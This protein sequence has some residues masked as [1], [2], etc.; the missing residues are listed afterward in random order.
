[1]KLAI[2]NGQ[3]HLPSVLWLPGISLEH[4]QVGHQLEIHGACMDPACMLHRLDSIKHLVSYKVGIILFT[5][6]PTLSFKPLE[7]PLDEEPLWVSYS[8]PLPG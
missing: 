5:Q 7:K 3:K 1:M 4:D 2:P 8:E 6:H